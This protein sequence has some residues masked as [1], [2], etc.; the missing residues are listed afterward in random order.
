MREQIK[1]VAS[2]AT[3][4]AWNLQDWDRFK[5]FTKQLDK[6]PYEKYFFNAVLEIKFPSKPGN[7]E[8]A[9]KY[10]DNART[11]LDT[12]ITSLLGESYNRAYKQIQ[13][14]Q[15]LT[16]LEEVIHYKATKSEEKKASLY[17]CWL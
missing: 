1:E 4:A 16:E 10:I 2:V 15:F 17:A 11:H 14:L 7:Y 5:R 3:Y 13:E 8:A 6:H 9:L 12:K